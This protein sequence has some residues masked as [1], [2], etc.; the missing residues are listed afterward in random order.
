MPPATSHFSSQRSRAVL[1]TPHCLEV[2]YRFKEGPDH[3]NCIPYS[4]PSPLPL[5]HPSPMAAK[6]L[7]CLPLRLGVF[8]F[9]ILRY[10]E[11]Q[12]GQKSA[13]DSLPLEVKIAI[14]A[15]GAIYTFAAILLH[16]AVHHICPF[17]SRASIEEWSRCTSLEAIRSIPQGWMI[18]GAIVPV[19][20]VA[21][22]LYVV[23]HYI[24]RIQKQNTEKEMRYKTTSWACIHLCG[25]KGGDAP[26][27]PT[28]RHIPLP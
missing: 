22:A 8:L 23:Y 17:S 24:K 26:S 20:L 7:F 25:R 6:F 16:L 13:W 28:R 27:Y 15:I 5:L 10:G 11:A 19:V 21:Y 3:F 9:T 14:I 2:C 18:A 4:S 1:L 12:E